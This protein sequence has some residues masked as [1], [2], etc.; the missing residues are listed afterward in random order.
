MQACSSC[1]K[2]MQFKP[3]PPSVS[4]CARAS[5]PVSLPEDSRGRPPWWPPSLVGSPL[6]FHSGPGCLRCSH[7]PS[8]VASGRA[9]DPVAAQPWPFSGFLLEDAA[10]YA[11]CHLPSRPP[12]CTRVWE[13][14]AHS[15]GR[16]THDMPLARAST[17]EAGR[18]QR[19][20]GTPPGKASVPGHPG[21]LSASHGQRA[22]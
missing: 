7:S 13:H 21:G 10:P 20:T 18:G 22:P 17:R 16:V 14:V 1:K 8:G 12:H 9:P 2:S 5:R 15:S 4:G 6:L 3:S 19:L 11:A